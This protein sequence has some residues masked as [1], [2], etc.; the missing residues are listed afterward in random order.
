M[1]TAPRQAFEEV[2]E[3][4]LVLEGLA[5]AALGGFLQLGLGFYGHYK[6]QVGSLFDLALANPVSTLGMIFMVSLIANYL[7]RMMGGEGDYADTL[8]VLSWGSLIANLVFILNLMANSSMWLLSMVAVV[9]LIFVVG[10]GLVQAHRIKLWR[11]GVAYLAGYMAFAVAVQLIGRNISGLQAGYLPIY[12]EAAAA[13]KFVPHVWLAALGLAVGTLYL[14]RNLGHSERKAR[15]TAAA[16][17]ALGVIFAAAVSLAIMKVDP[18][19][20]IVR[21]HLDYTDG[22]YEEAISVYDWTLSRFPS[23]LYARIYLA[24]ALFASGDD[25]AALKNYANMIQEPGVEALHGHMGIGAVKLVQ[26]DLKAAKKEFQTAAKTTKGEPHAWLAL[27][28]ARMEEWSKAMEAAEES[29][30][31]GRSWATCLVLVDAYAAKGNIESAEENIKLAIGLEPA[32]EERFGLE[33]EGWKGSSG[34]LT[35]DDLKFPLIHAA[36]AARGLNKTGT[37]AMR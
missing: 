11:C 28:Y 20:R 8:A 37:D 27:T 31:Y 34:K 12:S 10:L 32:L 24:H 7:V 17:G 18:A 6:L 13:M 29:L 25:A 21:A 23:D 36:P 4:R 35:R 22:H 16:A 19:G 5:I 2:L 3:R 26:G 14:M 33:A 9:W 30:N 15:M 1:F